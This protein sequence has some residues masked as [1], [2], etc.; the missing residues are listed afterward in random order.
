MPLQPPPPVPMPVP[1][2][3]VEAST[4]TSMSIDIDIDE[5]D[6]EHGEIQPTGIR[7]PFWAVLFV[8]HFGFVCTLGIMGMIKTIK[9][10]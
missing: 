5:S 2:D 10:G 9:D 6:W 3:D 1:V 7:D 4:A 8:V